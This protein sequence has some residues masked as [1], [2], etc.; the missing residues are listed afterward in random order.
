MPLKNEIHEQ[1]KQAMKAGD[2]L[3]KDCLR[4][5]SSA[6]KNKE[7][8]K[9]GELD[10]AEV[11]KVLVTLAKQRNESIEM[12]KKGNR[13][14]LVSKEEAELAIIQ[15]FLPK[16]L[17]DEELAKV[18]DETIAQVGA[19]GPADMGKVMKAI[20]PHTSGR[21]DGKKVSEAVKARLAGR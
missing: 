2:A 21:A 15:S 9:R 6:I 7:I 18:V 10:D 13:Q 5:V 14:D 16:P 4:F 19:V 12:Y 17:S 11:A 3:K 8:E 1:M 20:G